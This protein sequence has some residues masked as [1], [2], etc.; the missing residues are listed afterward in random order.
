MSLT[1][2]METLAQPYHRH[3]R[4]E[5]PTSTSRQDISYRDSIRL[6]RAVREVVDHKPTRHRRIHGDE[7]AAHG[8]PLKRISTLYH[9]RE[10]AIAAAPSVPSCAIAIYLGSPVMLPISPLESLTAFALSFLDGSVSQTVR[11]FSGALRISASA[12]AFDLR[13]GIGIWGHGSCT[14]KCPLTPRDVNED[15]RKMQKQ[16]TPQ[17]LLAAG[18]ADLLVQP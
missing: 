13:G 14:L 8:R 10:L 15:I 17:A 6:W 18:F 4:R 5:P 9:H 7:P 12:R 1:L 2:N 16:K 3:V 11:L